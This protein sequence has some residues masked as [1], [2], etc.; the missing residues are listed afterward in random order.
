MNKYNLKDLRWALKKESIDND[1][2]FLDNYRAFIT[3][4]YVSQKDIDKMIDFIAALLVTG[5]NNLIKMAYYLSI[6]LG[7]ITNDYAIL[8]DMSERLGYYPVI[9]L[10]MNK[11]VNWIILMR[12]RQRYYPLYI[13]I[14][15]LEQKSNIILIKE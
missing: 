5:D 1:K 14:S 2:T 3:D 6:H 7:I 4:T 15:I 13:G 8:R 12:Y 9:A 10:P 11:I